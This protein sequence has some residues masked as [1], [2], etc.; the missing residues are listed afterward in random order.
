MG[1]IPEAGR[2][3]GGGHGN[4][5]QYSGLENPTDTGAWWPTVRGVAKS[6]TWLKQLSTHTHTHTHINECKEFRKVPEHIV[7]T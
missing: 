1:S 6:R 5:L 7:N 3:P 4:P 2:S